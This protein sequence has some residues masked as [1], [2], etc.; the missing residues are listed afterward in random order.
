MRS[1]PEAIPEDLLLSLETEELATH[2][3]IFARQK[4][5]EREPL[6]LADFQNSLFISNPGGHKY[7]NRTE[8]SLAIAEAWVWLEVHGFLVPAEGLN[9][10][11]GFKTL[12]RRASK[13]GNEIDLKSFT[14]ARRLD[15]GALNPRIAQTVWSAFMR[16][17]FD[18]AAFHAMKAVE[19]AVRE[20]AGFSGGESG[21]GL[22]RKAFNVENGRL[23]D[24][25]AEKGERQALSDLFAGAIGSFKNAL[26]HRDVNIDDP[27]EALEIVMLANHLLRIV[28]RRKAVANLL[29]GG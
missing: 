9:G 3:L 27:D 29:K 4:H 17:E 18:V 5:H 22:M 24:M 19:V 8:V 15:K 26:S 1:L 6:H 25:Q 13:L 11:N 28:D 21:T 20:A 10:T 2:V 16:G 7:H 23:T 12:S 14:K